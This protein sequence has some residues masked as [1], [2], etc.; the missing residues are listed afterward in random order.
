MAAD[1]DSLSAW[2][3]MLRSSHP[4]Y[5]NSVEGNVSVVEVVSK[6]MNERTILNCE[7]CLAPAE[8]FSVVANE[9]RL[10]ILEA[11]WRAPHR[12][13]SFSER[14]RAAGMTDSAQFNRRFV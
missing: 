1:D 13:V 9:S 10:A 6:R 7:D 8:A 5:K 11:L 3:F 2:E 4:R 14:R 12:P